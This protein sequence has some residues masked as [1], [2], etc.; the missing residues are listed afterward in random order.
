LFFVLFF[1]VALSAITLD[2][3]VLQ[4]AAYR[5]RP[6]PCVLHARRSSANQEVVL[7]CLRAFVQVSANTTQHNTTQHNTTQH[8]TTPVRH[9]YSPD[10]IV[11]PLLRGDLSSEED[12][13]KAAC[14]V[15]RWFPAL[16]A[17]VVGPGLGRNESVLRIARAL[18]SKAVR[19]PSLQVVVLDGDGLWA[20][21]EHHDLVRCVQGR[22]GP[23]NR[24]SF[25]TVFLVN[26]QLGARAVLTPNRAG[27][28]VSL[29][30]HHDSWCPK[31]W[32]RLQAQLGLSDSD[33]G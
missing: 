5:C 27:T 26:R 30:H 29:A 12:I 33:T 18:L 17:L 7:R 2:V 6:E 20:V 1:A 8:N 23:C 10:V 25:V 31:E 24:I 22:G 16:H 32:Q 9:S 11:H 3:L 15:E 14:E 19:S 21:R 28:L 4:R 13:E